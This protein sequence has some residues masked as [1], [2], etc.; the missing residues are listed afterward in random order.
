MKKI[1]SLLLLTLSA[2]A[3]AQHPG[4]GQGPGNRYEQ[5]YEHRYGHQGHQG[6]W[7]R[8]YGG[9]WVWMV[10]ALI[11]GAII[12]EAAR[13]QPPVIIQ[14]QPMVVPLQPVQSCSPWTEVQNPDGT[15]TRTRTCTQ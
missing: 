6:H 9:G 3:M 8:G 11:G 10:P 14:Q 7:A 1:I 2:T 4:P 15:I 13:Q 5:R 12:Y